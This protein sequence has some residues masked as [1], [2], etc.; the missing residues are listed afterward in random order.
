MKKASRQ[1]TVAVREANCV[2]SGHETKPDHLSFICIAK[3]LE[4]LA[5]ILD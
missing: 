5:L 2:N 4:I 1:Q 3:L